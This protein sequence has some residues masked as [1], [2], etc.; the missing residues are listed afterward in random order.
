MSNPPPKPSGILIAIL[1]TG[2][3]ITGA[4]NS[5]WSKAQDMV[6]VGNCDD[7][8]PSKHKLFEQPTIQTLTMFAGEMLCLAAFT[9][10]T[11][12]FNP[13]NRPT[14][15]TAATSSS[16]RK[17]AAQNRLGNAPLS[18]P[19][20]S[21]IYFNESDISMIN[22]AVPAPPPTAT[23]DSAAVGPEGG[24]ASKH[25]A[26][27]VEGWRKA[28][29]FWAPAVCDIC[30]TTA[31]NIG[32][33]F[34]PVSAYQMLRGALV[35]WVGVFSVVFL[36]RQ[37]A[38]AQ[39]IAL[40]TVMLGVA[41]VGLSSVVGGGGKKE[42]ES[43][44]EGAEGEKDP[45]VGVLLILVAQVFEFP[46]PASQFVL[47]EKI[48]ERYSVEPL[49]AVGYEG[50]F[51]FLSTIAGI[52]VLQIFVG[53]T[54][55]G[56]GGYFDAPNGWK[57][58]VNNPGVWGS[59]I[60]IMISIAFFN[61]CGLAVTK[62][63]S[64]TA[65]STIDTCRTCLIWVVSLMLGWE[66]FKWLQVI[67]FVLLVYGTFVFNG[68]SKF[69]AW[70]GF[71]DSD[72]PS[73]TLTDEADL[74]SPE[75]GEG[76]GEG[77]V[78]E[79]ERAIGRSRSVDA[80]GRPVTRRSG[81]GR[82]GEIMPS[83]QSA[84]LGY[85]RIG[86]KREVKKATEAYWAN[87]LSA[88]ELQKV[89][90][91]QRLIRWQTLQSAGVDLI[92]SGDFTL[93]DHV[94]DFS[95]TFNVIPAK[96]AAADISELDRYFAMGRGRQ[97]D[98]VDLPAQEMQKWFDSNY[99][100]L[101]GEISSKTDFKLVNTKPVDEFEE[102]KAA[103]ITTRPVVL[104]PIT[105]LLLGKTGRDEES[106]DF[107]P[108]DVLDK[109]VPAVAELLK[110]L[111]AAGATEVQIDEPAL[112]LDAA[113]K[114]GP[115]FEKTYAAFAQ[116]APGLKITLATY[117]GRLEDNVN[118]VAKLPIH[119]LHIDLDRA[120]GQFDAVLAAIKPTKLTLSLGLVS[121]RNIWK[122]DFAASLKVTEKAIAELGAERVVVATSSSL[123]HTPVTLASETKLKPEVADWF[124]FATEKA[125]EVATLAKAIS[126]PES[127]K[128]ALEKNA[129]SIKA[130]RD[131]EANSD[132][133]VRE[134]LAAVTQKDYE[135]ANPY[136]VRREAQAKV[137]DL[138]TFPTT[139]IGSFPQTKEIRVARSKL[140]KGELTT[141]EY[142]KFIE[143][144]IKTVVEF[145]EKVGLDIL[146][147]GEPE[148]NDM[149]QYFGELLEGFVF[150]EAAWV[151]SYGSRY[152]RPPII[153][154]DVSRPKA[155]TVRWS[156]YAQSLSKSPVKGMLTG[157]V[158]ILNWSFPRADVSKEIQC[159]QLA[160]A[161]RDEVIDLEKAG[162]FA[163]QVDEPAIR[164][165]LPLR[166]VDWDAYLTWAVD[167]FRLSTAGV[168]DSTQTHSHFC[169]SDFNSIFK[170]I[171]ALDADVISIEASKSDLKLLEVFKTFNYPNS[172]GPGL[173]DIHSPRVPSVEEM[174]EKVAG[175]LN[176]LP[177]SD[178]FVNPDCGL[179]TRG[180]AETEKSLENLVAVAKWAREEYKTKV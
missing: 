121:G 120:A 142:E 29:L 31:M 50:F 54:P 71:H 162:I 132:A 153:V 152:V 165:G 57:E 27:G 65:R 18:R 172:I 155:M 164:E 24:V 167:S 96:Y 41:V 51:G 43:A 26:A 154:S 60:A 84:V 163:I 113:A 45:L 178:L 32:L 128:E 44:G 5:L 99:H 23:E 141:E 82:R 15:A 130:R 3:L 28:A 77:E 40:A 49:L 17:L 93:Y 10:S 72:L 95:T 106:A 75:D 145:Q 97:V 47:E 161:L 100:Y 67:G 38:K 118:Y 146:V 86:A 2:M 110:K 46:P 179:K 74:L 115:Q 94:L 79:E 143:Q 20:E 114:L 58:V 109:L 76:E 108:I 101:K 126:A 21:A 83:I 180:W 135:R 70:T 6:C 30:G 133:A 170:H 56:K 104:G 148:R 36:K 42:V 63:V 175:L 177:Q 12:R 91:E 80:M 127:V 39:W 151:Q 138:P 19:D 69:P 119:A 131:F 123:L 156:S 176:L 129:A 68:I 112:V 88:E 169:Y 89:A 52:I 147:H 11:S 171:I 139:T 107:Q 48:M 124:S 1:V 166:E 149:V 140:G 158:T 34:V 125:H 98:N 160:L 25:G 53:S 116:A 59:S 33:L 103:G 87:K 111:E 16:S 117:F 122:N 4:S 37:L 61:F 35:L 8:D 13:F 136:P 14:R 7:P 73:I 64:A 85:P 105:Y 66:H 90:K 22:E 173:Y 62:S 92:P 137:V 81:S 134:R 157:P 150:T 78:E 102:A 168:K 55:R 9:L 159:K 144:E 174:K